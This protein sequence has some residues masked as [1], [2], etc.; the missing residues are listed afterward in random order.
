M[1]LGETRADKGRLEE[2]KETMGDHERHQED[3]ALQTLGDHG[4]TCEIRGDQ[5]RPGIPLETI[6]TRKNMG[7][8]G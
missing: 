6:E 7:D 1:R 5:G 3:H 8:N 4:R 2:T